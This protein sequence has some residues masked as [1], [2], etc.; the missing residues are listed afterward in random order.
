MKPK[1]GFVDAGRRQDKRKG[2]DPGI[3][4]AAEPTET[5]TATEGCRT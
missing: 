3:W 5:V 1:T 2:L 4:N